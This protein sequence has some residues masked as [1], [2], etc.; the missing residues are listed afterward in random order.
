MRRSHLNNLVHYEG[1]DVYKQHSSRIFGTTQTPNLGYARA[2]AI[3]SQATLQA[4][5]AHHGIVPNNPDPIPNSV[6]PS[7]Q[8]FIV[9]TTNNPPTI[10]A[11]AFAYPIREFFQIL[12]LDFPIKSSEKILQLV[13]FF[14]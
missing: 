1:L 3:T 13:T 8:Q 7:P 6:N 14:G 11:L 10:D 12:E 9:S 4:T 5:I 2:I